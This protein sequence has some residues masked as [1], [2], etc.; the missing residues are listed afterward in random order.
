M[1]VSV[2]FNE[3]NEFIKSSFGRCA[4]LAQEFI[5]LHDSVRHMNDKSSRESEAPCEP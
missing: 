4:V 1:R 2:E 3:F 5:E